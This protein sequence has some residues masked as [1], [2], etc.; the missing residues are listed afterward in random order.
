MESHARAQPISLPHPFSPASTLSDTP[1]R[2]LQF[3]GRLCL[4]QLPCFVFCTTHT[5][6][7]PL[8]G[9]NLSSAFSNFSDLFRAN[10]SLM[11]ADI[12]PVVEPHANIRHARS[13]NN[14]RTYFQN[15]QENR[16]STSSGQWST[17]L[18]TQRAGLVSFWVLTLARRNLGGKK[19]L[20]VHVSFVSIPQKE[21]GL[22]R[23]QL[24]VRVFAR[25]SLCVSVCRPTQV[26]E[27]EPGY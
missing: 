16:Q 13:S 10:A 21:E 25:A 2:V 24:C 26:C 5:P 17:L 23:S 18:F 8:T 9:F 22:E 15:R 19:V 4:R 27:L 14:T 6:S 11:S 20:V 3:F 12:E 7:L 1:I